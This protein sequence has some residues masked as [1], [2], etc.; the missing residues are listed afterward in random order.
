MKGYTILLLLFLCPCFVSAQDLVVKGIVL[1]K[2]NGEPLIGATVLVKGTTIGVVTDLDGNFSLK[3]PA[4]DVQLSISYIGFKSS[5]RN[6]RIRKEDENRV[7]N[8]CC[9]SLG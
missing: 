4:K 7:R 9:R 1:D 5:D 2:N 8:R 6:S 3:V